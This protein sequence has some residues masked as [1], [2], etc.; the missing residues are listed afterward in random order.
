MW[1]EVRPPAATQVGDAFGV[2]VGEL[3]AHPGGFE[4]DADLD[5]PFGEV[6][7]PVPPWT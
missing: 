5:Q 7:L 4:A 2:E 1:I 6:D 3:R